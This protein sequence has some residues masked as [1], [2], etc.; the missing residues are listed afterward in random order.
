M[1]RYTG[2]HPANISGSLREIAE[3]C[4]GTDSA[5][6]LDF[7]RD[8]ERLARAAGVKFM[9]DAEAKPERLFVRATGQAKDLYISYWSTANHQW[10]SLDQAAVFTLDEIKTMCIVPD[11]VTTTEV[12][13][14]HT[15]TGKPT[16]IRFPARGHWEELPVGVGARTSAEIIEQ[17]RLRRLDYQ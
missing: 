11:S 6:L 4:A 14:N 9:G 8:V 1:T 2:T 3:R 17:Q 10:D 16:K 5:L 7:A 15:K 13:M 12:T